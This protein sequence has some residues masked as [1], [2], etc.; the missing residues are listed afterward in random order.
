M[1]LEVFSASHHFVPK[2]MD[3]CLD[4]DGTSPL[5]GDEL[6]S[7]GDCVANSPPPAA[8]SGDAKGGSKPYTRR[9]KP[10]YSYIALIAMAIRDSG[11]GRL[12]LAEINDYLM[13][14][15]PFF[16]GAYTGWRNS[17]RH[18]LSLNDCFLK[19]LRDPSR[20][21]GKDNYWMLNPHSEYTFAD[22]REKPRCV[23]GEASLASSPASGL[24]HQT[25]AE[26]HKMPG[27][28]VVRRRSRRR[29][30]EE[31]ELRAAAAG[32]AALLLHRAHREAIQSSPAKRLTLSEIYQFLQARFPFFRGSYQGWKTQ[33]ATTC[34]STS[35]SSSCP[36]DWADPGRVTT[37][38]STR[39]ASSCSRK[40]R[41]V[42]DRGASGGISTS[43][44]PSAAFACHG[45]GYNLDMMSSSMA[46][47]YDGHHHHHHHGPHASP[48]PG[49]TYVSSCPVP[50][51]G[52]EYG[53]DSSSSPVPSSPAGPLDGH[54]QY[55]GSS[56]HWGSG[57]CLASG[58]GGGGGGPYAK[59]PPLTAGSPAASGLHAGM[60]PKDFVLNFNGISSFHPSA[61]GSYYHHHH[62][63]HHQGV[64]QDIKPCVI[65]I[66]ISNPQPRS[67]GLVSLVPG[68]WSP[69]AGPRLL[70]PGLMSCPGDPEVAPHIVTRLL[71]SGLHAPDRSRI[72][73]LNVPVHWYHRKG[74]FPMGWQGRVWVSPY[75]PDSSSS[76]VPS[77][78]AGPL[79]GHP[80]YGGSSAHWA[81][82]GC[83]ASG[84]GGGG[85]GP[86]A[87]QPPLT[88][89]SPAASGL[90][91]GMSPY[92]LEPSYTHQTPRDP[93]DSRDP[94]CSEIS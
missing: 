64:C 81:S 57:G 11:S 86:Y 3:L 44:P 84:G 40:A 56:A 16:R 69:A 27:Q 66:S 68:R 9:P 74:G 55:G 23:T 76:P 41:S 18:N 24:L 8:H 72:T 37:G 62:H 14:K 12:T 46:G 90:H 93:R 22:G 20:P 5:S 79:D 91:A 13:T 50:S 53:P 2:P 15:F 59:Q 49:A 60:S 7:D 17:V 33:S 85:G 26:A 10:P 29:Q 47:G 65:I 67:A 4:T 21:W 1:K 82:G 88:A 32:E 61:S 51:A 48:G 28:L 58:G 80:Q 63:H 52:P 42:A 77:S 19:V 43:R 38:L 75:G 36:R 71:G 87:K 94:H 89:G 83:L 39:P 70:V 78:P 31:G 92:S 54:P 25:I 45:S 6:G 73:G 34:R 35:A 30:G